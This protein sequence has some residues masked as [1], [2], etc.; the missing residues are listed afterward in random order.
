MNSS[1][2]K[3]VFVSKWADASEKYGLG[4]ILSND[5]VGALFN[6]VTSM[7]SSMKKLT[8]V[9][10]WESENAERGCRQNWNL[11]VYTVP[12][13]RPSHDLDKKI[14]LMKYFNQLLSQNRIPVKDSDVADPESPSLMPFVR[15]WHRSKDAI[16]FLL[17][18]D[19][20]QINFMN[21]H[22]LLID[23][24]SQTMT[25]F[26]TSQRDYQTIQLTSSLQEWNAEDLSRIR[27]GRDLMFT[28]LAD[29]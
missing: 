4:Y 13:E 3:L 25:T 26:H 17:S 9:A 14:L 10:Y 16:V 1:T 15:Y 28:V 11:S 12:L 19:I 18:S 7:V 22:T 24:R 21:D 20:L 27:F 23:C 29:T 2:D 6:D 8:S 5:T